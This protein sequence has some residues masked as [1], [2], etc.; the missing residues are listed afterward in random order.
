MLADSTDTGWPLTSAAWYRG[1]MSSTMIILRFFFCKSGSP[2]SRRRRVRFA[3]RVRA[4]N[5]KGGACIFSAR[6]WKN[7][8]GAKILEMSPGDATRAGGDVLPVVHLV[9]EVVLSL[10][11]ENFLSLSSATYWF[12]DDVSMAV[13]C[14][15]RPKASR[16]SASRRLRSCSRARED[17]RGRYR[18]A[19]S[20][21]GNAT[22]YVRV[23]SAG[24]VGGASRV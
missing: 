13:T 19:V 8:M 20:G 10:I 1:S 15:R 4:R 21:S 22:H 12:S 3:T 6:V 11:T 7:E 14:A 5:E 18:G 23:G 24:A 17:L 16:G 9:G 2:V